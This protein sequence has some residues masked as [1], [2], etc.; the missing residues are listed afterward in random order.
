MYLRR[1][2]AGGISA[3]QKECKSDIWAWTFF[4]CGLDKCWRTV[5]AFGPQARTTNLRSHLVS[6]GNFERPPFKGEAFRI[7]MRMS[8]GAEGRG[9]GG[10]RL[11][12]RHMRALLRRGWTSCDC[13]GCG[14][15]IICGECGRILNIMWRC[16][17]YPVTSSWWHFPGYRT[18]FIIY[19]SV[20]CEEPI[21]LR[22]KKSNRKTTVC[23]QPQAICFLSASCYCRCF[24][25]PPSCLKPISTSFIAVTDL[26]MVSLPFV[27]SQSGRLQNG[28][29]YE[30]LMV[31]ASHV[32]GLKR[33]PGGTLLWEVHFA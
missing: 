18:Q 20:L 28:A 6:D 27:T 15:W 31:G 9:S 33:Q 4:R 19:C 7:Q 14:G 25:G 5:K 16:D 22:K 3:L 32:G 1:D 10:R 30:K 13:E 21:D 11:A 12:C 17:I 8:G 29:S 23:L 24:V 26:S 2:A